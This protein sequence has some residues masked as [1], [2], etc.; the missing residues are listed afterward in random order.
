MYS[1]LPAAVCASSRRAPV[2]GNHS[3]VT[4]TSRGILKTPPKPAHLT[5]E[6]SWYRQVTALESNGIGKYMPTFYEP[7]STTPAASFELEDVTRSLEE[8]T[9][10]VVD[11]K[12]GKRTYVASVSRKPDP[13][14]KDKLHHQYHVNWDQIRPTLSPPSSEPPSKLQ[15]MDWRDR[16]TTSAALGFRLTAMRV[17][18]DAEGGSQSPL[19]SPA[20]STTTTTT[21]TTTKKCTYDFGIGP[22]VHAWVHQQSSVDNAATQS[23]LYFLGKGSATT[24]PLVF[25]QRA[26]AFATA[27]KDFALALSTSLLFQSHEIIGSSVLLC[28]DLVLRIDPKVSIKWI[29]FSHVSER[30]GS[31]GEKGGLRPDGVLE[32][33]ENLAA[34]FETIAKS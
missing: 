21:T 12:L 28:Y 31:G 1:Q 25:K 29:D 4:F 34:L 3:S 27:L 19:L 13:R 16:T 2:G 30:N 22:K 5:S 20:T 8:T 33:V 32:G 23:L 15:Y 6:L 18:R 26:W 10:S 11:L 14:Y 9:L 7:T 24:T 17:T